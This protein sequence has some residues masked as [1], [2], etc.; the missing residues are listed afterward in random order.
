MT[1]ERFNLL[2]HRQMSQ[3]QA[4]RDFARQATAAACAA[5]LITAVGLLVIQRSI[6]TAAEFNRELS[7]ANYLMAPRHEE[8]RRLEEQ[9]Q[10]MVL[11][12]RVIEGLDARRSTSVLILNDLAAALPREVYLLRL[13]EN[14]SD[15]LVEGRAVDAVAIARFLER[16]STSAYLQEIKL[17]EIR[18]QGPE[19]VAA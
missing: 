17:G 16:L 6:S 3:Q 10:R 2:P 19:A 18:M 13:S 11:R 12:Q 1:N 7:E 8:S 14:G 4:W 15:F 9:Y 5:C